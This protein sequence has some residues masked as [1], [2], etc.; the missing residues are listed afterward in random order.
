MRQE[1]GWRDPAARANHKCPTI[2]E[3][4]NGSLQEFNERTYRYDYH[5]SLLGDFHFYIVK[6]PK[7]LCSNCG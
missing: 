5:A 7:F 4:E 1:G 3:F 6:T 2:M